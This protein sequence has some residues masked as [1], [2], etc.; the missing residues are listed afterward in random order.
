MIVL[1]DTDILIDFALDRKPYADQAG[2]LL[3]ALQVQPGTGFIAWHTI[4][5]FYYLVVP[6]RGRNSSKA[7]LTDLVQ[8]VEVAPTTTDSLRYAAK[9]DMKAF[10]DALQVAA[11]MACR[12]DVIATRNVR[13]YLKAP[14]RA[15]T[16]Q[17]V[18]NEV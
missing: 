9:L 17:E 13:D 6:I 16:P 15:A 11:A 12:A 1:I 14:L 8:F 4:S 2:K 5:N 18:L 7:F 3:D 10:E